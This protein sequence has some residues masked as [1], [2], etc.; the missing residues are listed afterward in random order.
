MYPEHGLM[1]IA[2]YARGVRVVDI[3][4]LVGVSV[5]IPGAPGM[6]EVG[7]LYF[8]DSDTWS[9]KALRIE[10]DGSFWF[11]GND[12]N[13]GLDVY[14]FQAAPGGVA[15]MDTGVSDWLL[16]SQV[17]VATSTSTTP[18]CLLPAVG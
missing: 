9:A 1:T 11:F 14:R 15:T 10:D 2:W 6:T 12:I 13:R 8:D 18:F 17:P 4:G 16:P 5:G 7:H 3:S